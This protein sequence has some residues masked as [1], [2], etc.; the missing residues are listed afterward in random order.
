VRAL[1]LTYLSLAAVPIPRFRLPVGGDDG[2]PLVLPLFSVLTVSIVLAHIV[3][4]GRIVAPRWLLILIGTFL[5]GNVA[6]GLTTS[7]VGMVDVAPGALSHVLADSIDQGQLIRVALVSSIPVSLV[8]LTRHPDDIRSCVDALWLGAVLIVVW[9][10]YGFLTH[11]YGDPSEHRLGYWGIRYTIATRN[12]DAVFPLFLA[13]VSATRLRAASKWSQT[14]LATAGLLLG[15]TAVVLSQSRGAWIAAVVGGLVLLLGALG[16]KRR[17][18]W[19]V[20]ALIVPAFT[21]VLVYLI[22]VIP[23]DTFSLVQ[24]YRTMTELNLFL[25]TNTKRMMVLRADLLIVLHRPLGI[26]PGL[27]WAENSYLGAFIAAGWMGGLAFLALSVIPVRVLLSDRTPLSQVLLPLVASLVTHSLF[28]VESETVLFWFVLSLGLCFV[29]LH[30]PRGAL[31]TANDS[32]D[33]GWR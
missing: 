9:G 4:G 20:L 12:S 25:A 14:A 3:R 30:H 29:A 33:V 13:I 19:L 8:L 16:E 7:L 15:T 28:N 26:G 2:I 5:F 22:S 23:F 32:S 17:K 11:S 1:Q 27:F 18:T 31:S 24:R 6:G 21:A 10:Y